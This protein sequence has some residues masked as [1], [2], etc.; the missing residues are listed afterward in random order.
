VLAVTRIIDMEEVSAWLGARGMLG[1]KRSE[2]GEALDHSRLVE[3]RWFTIP[4]SASTKTMLGDVLAGFF[5][6]EE[7]VLLYIDGWGDPP[8]YYQDQNLF[9]RFRQ[10]LGETAK[11]WEKPGHILNPGDHTDMLSLLRLALYFG[12]GMHLVAS[13][14]NLLLK[15][16]DYDVGS[17]YAADPAEVEKER[18][19]WLDHLVVSVPMQN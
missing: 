1:P 19:E 12:W 2:L 14:G 4:D 17:L 7:E 15:V 9:D 11:V 13:S 8:E 5:A 16:F 3:A 6:E 18:L 10:A